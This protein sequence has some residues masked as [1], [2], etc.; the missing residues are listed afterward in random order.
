MSGQ[1]ESALVLSLVDS[2]KWE[3]ALGPVDETGVLT[4]V[5]PAAPLDA[6]KYARRDR[7]LAYRDLINAIAVLKVSLETETVFNSTPIRP[8]VEGLTTE[9]LPD[10]RG[11]LGL[12][13]SQVV[14]VKNSSVPI[15]AL[16]T[17]KDLAGRDALLFEVLSRACQVFS[18]PPITPNDAN[19]TLIPNVTA[20]SQGE[21]LKTRREVN[22][23]WPMET[24]TFGHPDKNL[25][26]RDNQIAA[27]VARLCQILKNP[28]E[29]ADRLYVRI[30]NVNERELEI[31]SL[32]RVYWS[33]SETYLVDEEVYHGTTWWR[34][35][36][37]TAQEPGTDND[38]V[39]IDSPTERIF[40]ADPNLLGRNRIVYNTTLKT[41]QWIS[42]SLTEVHTPQIY[43]LSIPGPQIGQFVTTVPAIPEAKDAEFWRQKA[44]RIIYEGTLA[45]HLDGYHD[46]SQIQT[47]VIQADTTGLTGA[48]ELTF[49][50]VANLDTQLTYKFSALVKPSQEVT[51]L[52]AYNNIGL[53]GTLSGL[54]FTG[55][56]TPQPGVAG[57]PVPFSISLPQ[58][59]W[60][61]TL[62]YTDLQGV[63]DGFGTRITNNGAS[64]LEDAA[65]LLFQNQNGIKFPVGTLLDSN[66]IIF[67]S[68]GG[69]NTFNVQWTYGDGQFHIRH[70]TF[71]SRDRKIGRYSM[72]VNV[73][74]QA[75]VTVI[76][77]IGTLIPTVDVWGERD[78]YGVMPFEFVT[79]QPVTDPE[80]VMK[81]LP[82]SDQMPI[83]VRQVQLERVDALEPVPEFGGFR[84]WK[85]ECLYRAVRAVNTAYTTFV[86]KTA[87]ADIPEFTLDG[88]LWDKT[89][90]D[91]WMTAIE[92]Y[93]PRLRHIHNVTAIQ[94]ERQ[95]QIEGGYAVYN[96]GTYTDG[97]KFYGT[98]VEDILIYGGQVVQ[99]GAFTLSFP[100]HIGKPALIP[101][102]L[103]YDNTDV[104]QANA[105]EQQSPVLTVCQPWMIEA[106]IYIAHEDFWSPETVTTGL[107]IIAP[108]PDRYPDTMPFTSGIREGELEAV[109]Y[110]LTA[111]MSVEMWTGSTAEVVFSVS[112]GTQSGTLSLEMWTGSI[113]DVVYSVGGG[114]HSGTMTIEM[115]SGSISDVVYV[116]SGGTHSGT[117]T[118]E[119]WSGSLAITSVNGGSYLEDG[120]M[121]SGFYGGVYT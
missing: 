114:T 14:H 95:Y 20:W 99:Q 53:T 57:L 84:S 121:S 61:L 80:V 32:I 1:L 16:A 71:A 25:A 119:M 112:G 31:F 43:A 40:Q 116:E 106:G 21:A 48:G 108:P 115:W 60:E 12:V 85:Q 120:T 62:Q 36:Q 101:L 87:D 41:L 17:D 56:Y 28:F 104:R 74:T 77:D 78:V 54:T 13:S 96:D 111:A 73:Q 89:S 91:A 98:N 5:D 33:A 55:D 105:T 58:G 38:W 97:Q 100:G 49:P 59:G 63:T 72:R 64:I 39:E 47:G 117:T 4:Q 3:S 94:N 88:T 68:S 7:E 19:G 52:G 110:P 82:E 51:I 86:S 92:T 8:K 11:D 37:F 34:A 22:P 67:T 75:G 93:H 6:T 102:G 66:P 45:T 76:S 23:A 103:Y 30:D 109:V 83:Q 42:E 10:T 70:L 79:T 44:S 24:N 107:E 46:T 26:D 35:Q 27:Y 90:T 50:F 15:D 9:I 113:A 65:P 69:I 81:W 29:F 2:I 18:V 118:V